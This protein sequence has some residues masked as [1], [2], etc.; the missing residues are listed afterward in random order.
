MGDINDLANLSDGHTMS[1]VEPDDVSDADLK[2]LGYAS[3]GRN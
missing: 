2:T 1:E 3:E